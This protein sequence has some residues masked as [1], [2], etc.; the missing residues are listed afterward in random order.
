VVEC[1]HRPREQETASLT[2][3]PHHVSISEMCR[4]FAIRTEQS[5]RLYDMEKYDDRKSVSTAPQL[6]TGALGSLAG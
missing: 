4:K 6:L 3:G 5:V 2:I 1:T